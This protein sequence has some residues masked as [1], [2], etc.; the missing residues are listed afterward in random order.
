MEIVVEIAEPGRR[1]PSIKRFNQT[2]II[3]GRAWSADLVIADAEVDAHHVKLSFD[4]EVGGFLVEDLNSANGTRLNG[5]RLEKAVQT[6]F[7]NSLT[8]GQTTF[9]VHQ[10]ADAVA[11]A[12]IHSRTEQILQKLGHPV[13]AVMTAISAIFLVQ[14]SE[15]ISSGSQF[16]WN[17]QLQG[18]I[19]TAIGLVVWAML[20]GGI[21]KLLKHQFKVWAH[22]G[23][24]A[25]LIIASLALTEIENL[26]AFNFLSPSVSEL[27]QAFG[28]GAMIFVWV[29][30]GLIITANTKVRTRMSVA[31]GLAG[32]FLLTSFLLPRLQTQ[33]WVN[34]VPLETQSLSPGARVAP[35]RSNESFFL[36]IE[37]NI[38]ESEE[39]AIE[40]REEE[41]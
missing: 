22:L 33:N 24:A 20:W 26:L 5:R 23:L 13:I 10:K 36:L 15:F 38:R 39:R 18:L 11:P 16:S 41:T 34:L 6:S 28:I 19:A 14:Y 30:L 7:G 12:K 4:A 40:A 8:V 29:L 35:T 21:T 3:V 2:E 25:G 27:L 17:N 1:A 9:R 31:A 37:D 32:L